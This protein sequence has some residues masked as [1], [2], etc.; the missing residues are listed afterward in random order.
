MRW[1]GVG[2]GW[3]DPPLATTRQFTNSPRILTLAAVGFEVRGTRPEPCAL[4]KSLFFSV[5]IEQYEAACQLA[6]D[7]YICSRWLLDGP[8]RHPAHLPQVE[9]PKAAR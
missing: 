2:R 6:E 1:L 7:T 5:G 9:A 4:P 3:F 8:P